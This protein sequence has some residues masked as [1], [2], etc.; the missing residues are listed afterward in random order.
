MYEKYLIK[1]IK[2][3]FEE[4]LPKISKRV[5]TKSEI[6][7]VNKKLNYYYGC[8]NRNNNAYGELGKSQAILDILHRAKNN[9]YN[10]ML[11]ELTDSDKDF[12][13]S[14]Q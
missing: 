1:F 4:I 7:K 9:A 3:Y 13:K 12:L 10:L 8:Y 2:L 14:V 11:N 5:L 6:E